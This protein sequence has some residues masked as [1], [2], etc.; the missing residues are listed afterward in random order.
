MSSVVDV[1]LLDVEKISKALFYSGFMESMICTLLLV[2]TVHNVAATLAYLTLPS[3]RR[4]CNPSRWF[5]DLEDIEGARE[6]R[7][8][9][10]T[11]PTIYQRL[12]NAKSI[13]FSCE[14]VCQSRLDFL[15]PMAAYYGAIRTYNPI[16]PRERVS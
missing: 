1:S 15:S 2:T 10:L 9:H 11:L 5:R 3:H 4:V 8:G 16:K 6:R 12:T 13:S 7:L 14:G